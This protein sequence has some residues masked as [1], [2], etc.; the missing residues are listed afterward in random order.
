MKL[1]F[2]K[3]GIRMKTELNRIKIGNNC[4]LVNTVR[5]LRDM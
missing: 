4:A 1:H 2:K 5:D 3:E